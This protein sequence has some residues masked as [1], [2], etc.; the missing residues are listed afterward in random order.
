MLLLLSADFF[1]II[2]F[3][4]FFLNSELLTVSN[5]LDSIQDWCPVGPD[6]GLNCLQ[7]L[8]QGFR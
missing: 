3:K 7:R 5:D 6:L 8:S 2:V 4:K 1:R